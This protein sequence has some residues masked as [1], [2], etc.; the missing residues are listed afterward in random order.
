MIAVRDDLA[1]WPAPFESK[2]AAAE[3]FG[4]PSLKAEAWANGLEQRDDGWW[5]RWEV[6][7]MAVFLAR[8]V[9]RA[10]VLGAVG[11]DPLS[12]LVGRH[13]GLQ[14]ETDRM[15]A[16]LAQAESVPLGHSDHDLHLHRPEEWRRA[17]T[18]FL[19]GID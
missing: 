7:V 12:T 6:D 10:R 15:S 3:F 14:E 13:P 8:G 5:P 17:L 9:R 16:R 4:G 2:R 19:D 18:A 11:G 1:S